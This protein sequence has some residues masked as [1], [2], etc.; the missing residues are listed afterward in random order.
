MV[1]MFMIASLASGAL[2]LLLAAAAG[3]SF[4]VFSVPGFV[5]GAFFAF[6]YATFGRGQAKQEEH[7]RRRKH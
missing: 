7:K 6:K 2:A 3:G 5:V 4:L 1:L